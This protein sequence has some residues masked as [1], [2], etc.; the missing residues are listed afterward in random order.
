MLFVCLWVYKVIVPYHLD[1]DKMKC[2]IT[3]DLCCKYCPSHYVSLWRGHPQFMLYQNQIISYSF[4]QHKFYY[5][6]LRK[7]N[8]FFIKKVLRLWNE[9]KLKNLTFILLQVRTKH[10]SVSRRFSVEIWELRIGNIRFDFV[11]SIQCIVI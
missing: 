3:T 9:N 10:T 6:C 11:N 2:N 4:K 1:H 7:N 5:P 8:F